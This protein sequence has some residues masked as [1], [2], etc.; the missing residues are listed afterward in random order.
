MDCF[1][2]PNFFEVAL[3]VAIG[4][5]AFW[6]Q[7]FLSIDVPLWGVAATALVGVAAHRALWA[8]RRW[9]LARQER[10]E[11]QGQWQQEVIDRLDRLGG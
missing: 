3:A 10:E 7:P 2:P 8:L 1:K 11:R 5:A 4:T 6:V 9:R